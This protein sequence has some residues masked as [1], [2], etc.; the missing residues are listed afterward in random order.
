M[1]NQSTIAPPQGRHNSQTPSLTQTDGWI[2]QNNRPTL[3]LLLLIL[4]RPAPTTIHLHQALTTLWVEEMLHI[5]LPLLR[6][7]HHTNTLLLPLQRTIVSRICLLRNP[8]KLN[9]SPLHLHHLHL[10]LTPAPTNTSPAPSQP[11]NKPSH[12]TLAR[13]KIPNQLWTDKKSQKDHLSTHQ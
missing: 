9:S 12:T 5:H 1:A 10:Q 11:S 2:S 7:N 13:P 4:L 6:L 8:F 3:R